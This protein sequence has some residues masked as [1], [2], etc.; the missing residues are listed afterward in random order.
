[1]HN[2]SGFLGALDA[3]VQAVGAQVEGAQRWKKG[4]LQQMFV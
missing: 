2:K 4:L 3:R 1:M